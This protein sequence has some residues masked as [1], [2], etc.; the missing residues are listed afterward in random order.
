MMSAIYSAGF[1]RVVVWN[2]D[3][4]DVVGILYAK[5]LMFVVPAVRLLLPPSPSSL[6]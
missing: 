3:R 4:T 6:L 5:D 2:D 1:S